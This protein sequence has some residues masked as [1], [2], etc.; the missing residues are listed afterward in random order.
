MSS[1]YAPIFS[2]V[3]LNDARW[4]SA[5]MYIIFFSLEI[6]LVSYSYQT[7]LSVHLLLHQLENTPRRFAVPLCE[8]ASSMGF[9]EQIF[10]YLRH[11]FWN[12]EK[13]FMWS[14]CLG[15]NA[16]NFLIQIFVQQKWVI[17]GRF[18]LAAHGVACYRNV[19]LLWNAKFYVSIDH[20]EL[21][22]N[23][24]PMCFW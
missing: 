22:W 24:M 9:S 3:I 5:C 7:M 1:T 14:I 23:S 2:K 21:Y 15:E 18:I 10:F 8:L 6:N 4:L 16:Y 17:Q 13:Y 11:L 19:L 20:L 12:C